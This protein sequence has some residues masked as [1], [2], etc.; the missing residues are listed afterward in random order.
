MEAEQFLIAYVP[1]MTTTAYA[2]Q[3]SIIL[4]KILLSTKTVVVKMQ[5]FIFPLFYVDNILKY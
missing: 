1:S 4:N 5:Y 2:L 3:R